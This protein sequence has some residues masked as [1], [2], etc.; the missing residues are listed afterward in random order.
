MTDWI[1]LTQDAKMDMLRTI[2][3]NSTDE[4][5]PTGQFPEFESV[6]QWGSDFLWDT[7]RIVASAEELEY[8]FR[9][10]E[11]VEKEVM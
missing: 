1:E 5:C 6:W 11:W 7:F 8:T 2:A 3:M 4:R 9:L 10:H